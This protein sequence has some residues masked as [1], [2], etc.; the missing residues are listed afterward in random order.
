MTHESFRCL[1]EQM[2]SAECEIASAPLRQTVPRQLHLVPSIGARSVIGGSAL[3]P[4]PT[5]TVASRRVLGARA[6]LG[7]A[8]ARARARR[9]E[10]ASRVRAS[11]RLAPPPRP[12]PRARRWARALPPKARAPASHAH[13]MALRSAARSLATLAARRDGTVAARAF[14]TNAKTTFGLPEDTFK[15]KVRAR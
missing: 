3:E 1:L 4:V 12:L 14:A 9:P 8:L 6:R 10:A 15:R 2:S 13:A 11:G 5:N 7:R